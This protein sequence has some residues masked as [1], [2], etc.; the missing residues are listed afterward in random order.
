[1][2]A[3]AGRTKQGIRYARYLK[4]GALEVRARAGRR[5]RQGSTV[6][7]ASFFVGELLL[8]QADNR[9]R[10]MVCQGR[11]VRCCYWAADVQ[12][13]FKTMAL[14][15]SAA[16]AAY[17]MRTC[18]PIAAS[19]CH[20]RQSKQNVAGKRSAWRAAKGPGSAA[21]ATAHASK[22]SSAYQSG[23]A[24]ASPQAAPPSPR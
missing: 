2:P 19:E 9:Y 14:C 5:Y 10:Y 6:H 24:V 18:A 20:A 13:A 21:L 8:R 11:V 3:G 23:T 16:T 17:Q 1:M 12:T 7:S 15:E 4:R 22:T